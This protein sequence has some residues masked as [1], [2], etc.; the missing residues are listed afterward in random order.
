MS[1]ERC[2]V[3]DWPNLSKRRWHF[4]GCLLVLGSMTGC[5]YLSAMFF[6]PQF[7][8]E[9]HLEPGIVMEVSDLVVGEPHPYPV[10]DASRSIG[11]VTGLAVDANG[12]LVLSDGPRN[13]LYEVDGSGNLRP[14]AG[15]G[16]RGQADGSGETATFDQPNSLIKGPDDALYLLDGRGT[17]RRIGPDRQVS[18]IGSFDASSPSPLMGGALVLARDPAGN[19]YMVDSG[20][21]RILKLAASGGVTVLAGGRRCYETVG[22]QGQCFSDGKGSAAVFNRLTGIRWTRDGM[23]SLTDSGNNRVRKVTL[24]GSVV[25]LVGGNEYSY[26]DAKGTQARL[27]CRTFVEDEAGNLYLP[28]FRT[29]LYENSF[30]K[31]TPDGTVTTVAIKNLAKLPVSDGYLVYDQNARCFFAGM[32][33]GIT[34]LRLVPG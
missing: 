14:Y 24:D 4:L 32:G 28:D 5:S 20:N 27:A 8:V 33:S 29:K 13:R 18:T 34:K 7:R 23:L 10:E 12:S 26:V 25:T 19:S 21:Q 11:M 2:F 22:Q 3:I 30:R 17:V 31:V 15:T 6:P 9:E 16:S 1:A